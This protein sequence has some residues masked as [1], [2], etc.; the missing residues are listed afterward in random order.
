MPPR[1]QDER[2]RLD[3][4]SWA[5]LIEERHGF[6]EGLTPDQQP[7]LPQE[8]QSAMNS[9]R[10]EPSDVIISG[11]RLSPQQVQRIEDMIQAQ[12]LVMMEIPSIPV[13]VGDPIPNTIPEPITRPMTVVEYVRSGRPVPN[14]V[15][16]PVTVSNYQYATAIEATHDATTWTYSPTFV[17]PNDFGVEGVPPAKKRLK[18]RVRALPA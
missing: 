13:H 14:P 12:N 1:T 4:E 9:P 5:R 3:Q 18:P 17:S 2:D 8:L 6:L 16:N 11:T 10:S 15:P 7:E